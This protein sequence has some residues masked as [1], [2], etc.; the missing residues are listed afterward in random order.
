[1]AEAGFFQDQFCC[2]LCL[3]L[4]KDL[5]TIP[6][7]HS[8]CMSCITDHWNQ[9][10]QKRVYSCPQCRQTFRPRPAINKNTM[11]AE[12]VEKPKVIIQTA[13]PAE[14]HENLLKVNRHNLMNATGQPQKMM[15][16]QHGKPLEIYCRTD[17]QCICVFCVV[18][19]HINHETVSTAAERTEKQKKLDETRGKFKQQIQEREVK[20]WELKEAVESQK[21][22]AQ[23]AVEDS[24]RIFTELIQSIE[25][26]RSEITQMIRDREKT[27]VSQAEGLMERLEQEIDELRRRNTE[28]E[29]LSHTDDDSQFLWRLPFLYDPPDSLDVFSITVSS[30]D[31]VRESVSQLRQKLDNFCRKEIEKMSGKGRCIPTAATSEFESRK[32]LLKYFCR[33]NVDLNTVHENLQLSKKN[34]V[35]ANTNVDQPYLDHPD[36][37]DYW[38]QVLCAESICERCYWEVEWDGTHDVGVSVSYKSIRRKGRGDEC[39]FGYNTESWSLDCNRSGYLF[40]HNNKQTKLLT[41]YDGSRIGVYVDQSAGILSFY[42][43]SDTITLLHRVQTTFTQPLYPGIRIGFPIT[44]MANFISRT[45]VKLLNK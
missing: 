45:S 40:C 33:L 26:R 3:D 44:Y 37:F 14:Q 7:G 10:D 43:V 24:E 38:W 22:S 17:Q 20:L 35:I 25:K 18:E 15:C 8:Y 1:M 28:L 27:V 2:P 23:T 32:E 16:H 41:K 31:D 5:V 13:V 19:K 42:S 9:E 11:L 39:K 30:Y 36:R 29:Q 12:V 21:R 34:R 6:C 4:L